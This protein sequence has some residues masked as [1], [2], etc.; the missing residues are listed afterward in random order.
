MLTDKHGRLLRQEDRGTCT[1]GVVFD[2]ED[3]RKLNAAEVRKKYPRFSGHCK[4]CG[5]R[6]IYYASFTHYT[7]GDW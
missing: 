7:L 2:E 4:A 6:G 1:H 5:Y 3:A